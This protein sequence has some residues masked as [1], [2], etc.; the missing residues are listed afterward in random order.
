MF[1]LSRHNEVPQPA[2]RIQ[3][4]TLQARKA[5]G[6]V[7]LMIFSSFAAI[8]FNSFQAMALNDADQ[9]GLSYAQEYL[10]NTQPAD[11]DTDGDG[12]PDGWEWKYG[13]DPLD[14]STSGDNGAT[15]DP[16]GDGLTNLVEYM[17]NQPSSWDSSSTPSILDNGVWWNGTVPV[18]GWSEEH[19]QTLS[20]PA[21]GDSGS[22]GSGTTVLCDE[23]PPG[24][25]CNNGL[26]DDGDGALDGLDSDGDGDSNCASDDDDGDGL[27][28]EDPDGWDT[29]GDGMDDGWE[30]AN[31][32]DPTSASGDNGSNGDPDNDG[33]VNIY[34]YVNPG[35]DSQCG[36]VDCFQPGPDAGATETHSP[37]NPVAMVGPG[38]CATITAEVDS[39]TQ[40]D[41]QRADTDRD[42]VNDGDEALGNLTDPTAQ[43]TD[44]DGI[45]DGIEINSGYGT[46]GQTLQAS[47]PRDNNTDGDQF[48]DGEEDLNG[49]GSLQSN[50]TDPTRREDAGDF[51]GDGLENW[52]ENM[53][54]TFWDVADSDFGGVNDFLELQANHSTD[55]CDSFVAFQTTHS[56]YS[57]QRLTVADS[58][59]FNPNG[60]VG[61]YNVSGA[62]TAFAYS[63]LQGSVLTGVAVSPP[64]GTLSVENWNA[65][66][67]HTSAVMDGTI[68]NTRS[69]CDDDYEDTDGDGLANWEEL[70]GAYGFTSNPGLTDTDSDGQSDFDE[71]ANGTLT[72]PQDP[73]YN[74]LDTD[75][76]AL[77]DYFETSTNC[78]LSAMGINNGTVDQFVTDP[79]IWDTDGGGIN[80]GAEYFDS[81]NPEVGNPHDDIHLS[82][83]DGDGIPDEIEN[84]TGTNWMDPDTDGGGMSDGLEC[85][86]PFWF[87][88][89]AGSGFDPLD[90]TDDII[91]NQVIF[92]AE[93]T[94]GVVDAGQQ[95]WWRQYTYDN[96]TGSA[97]GVDAS[98]HP[99]EDVNLVYNNGSHL[100]DSTFQNGTVSWRITFET[101]ISSGP[102]PMPTNAQ[103]ITSSVDPSVELTRTHLT[104]KYDVVSGSGVLAEI[105]VV[106]PEVFYSTSV[107]DTTIPMSGMAY[108]TAVDGELKNL[109]SPVSFA[110]NV[111]NGVI[112]DAGAV[113]A[114]EK[115][116]A[117]QDF[118]INGNGSTTFV[119]N[120]NGSNP[121]GAPD[122][123]NHLLMDAKQGS[124]SE[125]T[126]T[127]V[128]MLRLADIPARKVSGFKGGIWNGSGYTVMSNHHAYWGEVRLQTNPSNS[129]LDLGW[130]PFSPCPIAEDLEIVNETWSP[131]SY[132]RD[133]SSL[134]TVNGT[135]RF[136]ENQTAAPGVLV[137][138]YLVPA[139]E[140]SLVP[141]P[142]SS[143][144][145]EMGTATTDLNGNFSITGI[146]TVAIHSGF[147]KVVFVP[148]TMGIIQSQLIEQSWFINV[149]DDVDIVHIDPAP[150]NAPNLGAGSTTTISGTMS[151]QNSP[152][153]A[154][155]ELANHTLWLNYTTNVS[156][157]IS[158]TAV[159]G[160][161]GAWEFTISLSQNEPFANISATVE[162]GGW[163]DSSQSF[164]GSPMHLRA[165]SL[166]LTFV[167]EAAPNITATVQGPKTNT[168]RLVVDSD[169]WINGTAETVSTPATSLSGD[170]EVAIRENGTG[171]LFEVIAN[172][173]VSGN[174]A[175]S[176]NLTTAMVQNIGAGAIDLRLR[177]YPSNLNSTD[178]V[179]LSG[180]AF[181][182]ISRMNITF[183][184]PTH[185]RGTEGSYTMS[186]LDHRGQSPANVSGIYKNSFNGALV[187][188]T[189]DPSTAQFTVSFTSPA[190]LPGG[191][192]SWSTEFEGSDYFEPGTFSTFARLQGEAGF[193][194]DPPTLVDDW[195]HLGGTN[196]LTSTLYDSGLSQAI[197]G[198]NSTVVVLLNDPELGPIEV[199]SS[200]VNTTTGAINVTLTAPIHLPS[201]VYELNFMIDFDPVAGTP[202]NDAY[203]IYAF[204]P[205]NPPAA[206]DWGISSEAVLNFENASYSTQ[207]N[208]SIE[209][210]VLVTD[211]ANGTG[212]SGASVSFIFDYGGGNVSMGTAKAN[213]TGA[214]VL[215]WVPD[216]IA[217]EKY[218]IAAIMTD[219][220][221][222]TLSTTDAGR[223]LG[224]SSQAELTVQVATSISVVFPTRI[225]AGLWFNLNG[226]VLDADN[227]SR[228]LS[229]AVQL[230][231]FWADN[232]E[233]VLI[234]DAL[235]N[236][237]GTFSLSVPT[238]T[239]SNGTE[240]GNH[241]LVIQVVND[242][243]PF[244][245]FGAA[246]QNILVMGQTTI[247]DVTPSSP[248]VVLRG[249]SVELNATLKESSNLYQP[250]AGQTVAIK[251]DDTWLVEQMTDG[252]GMISYLHLIPDTQPLGSISV[253]FYYNETADLLSTNTTLTT[254]TVSTTT[255]TYVDPI[256]ANPVAGESFEINGSV[257][258]DNGSG[259]INRDGTVLSHTIQ[260]KVNDVTSGFSVSG[261]ILQADGS[262]NATVTLLSEFQRGTH[263]LTAVF[264]PTVNYYEESEATES[265]T[266][267]GFTTLQF[268]DPIMNGNSPSLLSATIR[269]E[270]LEVQVRIIENTNEP[271]AG[272]TITVNLIG[273]SVQVVT[274]SDSNG[275]AWANLTLPIGLT[276]G[277]NHLT[278][279]Y[280]GLNTSD[281]LEPS[282]ANASF[283]ALAR[284]LITIDEH[285]Q[286][287]VV[288]QDLY[289]NGTLL[290][291]LGL[292]LLLDGNA[293]AGVVELV[294]DG[295]VT[296]FVQTNAT[297]GEFSFVWQ[298]PQSFY[299]GNHSVEVRYTADPAW[300][301]PGASEANSANP[302]YYLPSNAS[303]TFGVQVPTTIVLA[304]PGG[305]VDRG[306]TIW[307]NGTLQDI[308]N[309]GLGDRA[310]AVKLNGVFYSTASTDSNGNFNI[311]VII[312]TETPL[313]P[314]DI[315]VEFAGEMFYLSSEA[316]GTWVLFSPV[317]IT[318]LTDES[319]AI[320]ENMTLTGTVLDN[321]L[322]PV[323]NHSLLIEVGGLVITQD[324]RTDENGTFT[325]TW[326]V[327]TLSIGE[328]TVTAYAEQQ[329][330]YRAG[331]GS[332][333]F[334]VA[335]ESKITAS[336]TSSSEAVRGMKWDL[337][338]RLYD[339]D[340]INRAGI[341]DQRIDLHLN[342]VLNTYATTDENGYWS[343][344]ISVAHSMV[345]GGHNISMHYAGN[346]T[347][348]PSESN[349]TGM[350]HAQV[351]IDVVVTSQTVIRG[352]SL[353]PVIFEG[354]LIEVGGNNSIISNTEI[355]IS[356]ICG[357]DGLDACEILWK[358]DGSF[359]IS[360]VVGF[361]HEPGTIYLMLSYP[362]NS[363]QYLNPVSVNRSVSLMVDL[364]FEVE[365]KDLVPGSQD[366]VEG[367]VTIFDKNAREQGI[368]IR[369]EDIPITAII[370]S[371]G[372]NNTAYS[373]ETQVTDSSGTAYFEFK[374]DPPYSDSEYWGLIFLELEIDDG[375]QRISDDTLSAFRAT[376]ANQGQI[377]V[378][379][380][381]AEAETPTWFYVVG[382][383][384]IAAAIGGYMLWK[385]REDHIKELSDIFSYT[386]ELLA[387]GD[388]MREAIFLCY[389]NL[390]QVLMRHGYLRRD[391]E[392]VREFEMAI[393]KALPINETS[394]MALDQVFEEARYS[395]HEMTE[396]HK[397][398]AQESLRGVLHDIDTMDK[399][400]VPA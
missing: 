367:T 310:L 134:I 277:V 212:I 87:T 351:V 385:R 230:D 290:D 210:T 353:Y 348:M 227:S 152:Q 103:N 115:V 106:Q 295:N 2:I 77:N 293:S 253:T 341:P 36:G 224:N 114:W 81:T 95:H 84:L 123:A 35:W 386:A 303:S 70:T 140:T 137:T 28:D 286:L 352:D 255:I 349:L 389:E 246:Q 236:S 124:C 326:L 241:V 27:I 345:R 116:V 153:L 327:Q 336:F 179:N 155:E 31:G 200:P 43:D 268:I 390:C 282:S 229:S 373:V 254:I 371:T 129:N 384:L 50:E 45:S 231:V 164:T 366:S 237:N 11:P 39:I 324:V 228:P 5:L 180:Q 190:G 18:R 143:P 172:L 89:C 313:G 1:T 57:S 272:A 248:L 283:V 78:T 139:D 383:L 56:L 331:N 150:A 215:L 308:V 10:L 102:V 159:V 52:E 107:Q 288:N 20:T 40:T 111:T 165:S 325:Y 178:D 257:T 25:I 368:D 263:N 16:D 194:P 347:F 105:N 146:P 113:S 133:G 46:S 203:Y 309:I 24:N 108:E 90:P 91:A 273:T 184:T 66:F 73:C 300:G 51:D 316:N 196:W 41:P 323:V 29:D 12:L 238:D 154:V 198:N 374:A 65:S 15:G 269:N 204:D 199:G 99:A 142:A 315:S 333:T 8:E 375:E 276:P 82:D 321:N 83:F 127:F 398:F 187:N 305:T 168:S 4:D 363:S 174:F 208:Q 9:D 342:G 330:Y 235:T 340:D 284:T 44:G 318:L 256:T 112:S 101:P 214:A 23:D 147:Q 131:A 37:C 242:S 104:H 270:T 372:T 61:F 181:W 170:L 76:D 381:V 6:I 185:I 391:F 319:V 182:M 211:V 161:G 334:F 361:E 86:Q 160:E 79:D 188:T 364:D 209:L 312:P 358:S 74:T 13:L 275:I 17:V 400:S 213:S 299:A 183:D 26:D 68:Q 311:P 60:G 259:V 122:L 176:F 262:W 267:R 47:D 19:V 167:V 387:A 126:T 344:T 136:S 38:N 388:E 357:I 100:P 64:V 280:A 145:R 118:L 278:A 149:T 130:I 119:L 380:A 306:D 163:T 3:N 128:T 365:F 162:F 192:Y 350:V 55:P 285:T 222:A 370:T 21:C 62:L 264:I 260:F 233:E 279:A 395:A 109:S 189:T 49:D 54:C 121:A 343:A 93:N 266:S 394:L 98:V 63:S 378:E 14:A 125:F 304:N 360:G 226:T 157:A 392:T 202:D 193:N 399:V 48:D 298:V 132:D 245:L 173:S 80:D 271:L 117:I 85:P 247:E 219:N 158:Q 329:G 110:F 234:N 396:Q 294:I 240:R 33:L 376:H 261:G 382:A 252:G 88:G 328:H 301:N 244:Y 223:W 251:F 156:G 22:D 289:L 369:V 151:Y 148:K 307:L 232:P 201:G 250:L 205:M 346:Q 292:P 320:N 243:N 377:D 335:H 314:A 362:G 274:T 221:S 322:D 258:S 120:S 332:T 69:Y 169:V 42:G 297:T 217:P 71:V 138:A 191:D 355:S 34:E 339:D 206:I 302:P 225:T 359:V 354:S 195:T 216:S 177:F 281:G 393:R 287:M 186:V 67:C 379:E 220:L 72:D 291:N 58:S 239:A 207:V 75:G 317:E 53:T 175:T 218:D 265:F 356:T 94:S 135:L 97:Y 59:G 96:Y 249:D 337:E 197:I 171:S 338:G 397:N 7:V 141:G 166:G 144:E 30:H 32:L 92:Y 296:A